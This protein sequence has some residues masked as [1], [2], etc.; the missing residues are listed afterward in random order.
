MWS[1]IFLTI[2]EEI[3]IVS[4]LQVVQRQ[5]LS[6]QKFVE[7]P[8]SPDVLSGRFGVDV[9]QKVRICFFT[10]RHGDAAAAV[11][12]AMVDALHLVG[13]ADRIEDRLAR[14]R[15]AARAGQVTGIIV[16]TDQPE[17][18]DLLAASLL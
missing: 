5:R 16:T 8:Q 18:L 14:W 12:D 4:A 3:D 13:A 6:G 7:K 17:A 11:P 2:V 10:G 9:I 1:G 15:A